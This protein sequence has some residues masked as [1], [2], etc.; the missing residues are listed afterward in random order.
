[1][2][3]K[4]IALATLALLA[5]VPAAAYTLTG[6]VGPGGGSFIRPLTFY[7]DGNVTVTVQLSSASGFEVGPDSALYYL[8][9]V[10]YDY[11][12]P[13]TGHPQGGSDNLDSDQPWQYFGSGD[14]DPFPSS[15]SYDLSFPN[16]QVRR[17]YV[18]QNP[19]DPFPYEIGYTET[20][21][22]VRGEVYG[23]DPISYRII[24]GGSAVVPEPATWA[25]LIGGFGAV[26]LRLRRQ[27]LA[28]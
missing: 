6:T 18:Y 1:M 9:L 15:Y 4:T 26:G 12:D 25:L 28:A 19:G 24:V 13:Q 22:S 17:D 5:A 3:F 16:A 23:N 10:Y 21:L 14:L 2:L 8:N 11:F 20:L 7:R 27:P